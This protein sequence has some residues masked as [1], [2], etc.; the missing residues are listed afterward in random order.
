[1][2]ELQFVEIARALTADLQLLILDEPTSSLT[3]AEV[4]KLFR[5]VRDLRDRGTRSC[6][7]RTGS[8]S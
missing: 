7:S 1:M 5:I 4:E 8:R 6:S 3:P 2:A